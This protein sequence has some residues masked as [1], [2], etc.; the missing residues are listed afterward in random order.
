MLVSVW[1]CVGLCVCL[2]ISVFGHVGVYVCA[3]MCVCVRF[4]EWVYAVCAYTRARHCARVF[5]ACTVLF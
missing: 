5:K 1:I 2:F 4:Y 3:C